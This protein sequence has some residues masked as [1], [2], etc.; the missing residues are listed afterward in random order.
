[1]YDPTSRNSNV[2]FGKALAG[3]DESGC[4]LPTSRKGGRPFG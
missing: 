3:S 2:D 1:M 4:D